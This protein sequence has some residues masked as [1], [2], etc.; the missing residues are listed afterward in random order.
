VVAIPDVA[1]RV[2]Y[3]RH[4]L[5]RMP[6]ELV[7]DVVAIAANLNET[8]IP[9][10]PQ[11]LLSISLALADESANDI[12]RAALGVAAS[13]GQRDVVLLLGR[14]MKGGEAEDEEEDERQIPDFG[15]GRPLTLGERKSLARK[16]DRDLIMRVLR[17]PHADVIEIL[18]GNPAVTEDDVI[19]LAA[20]RPVGSTILR[21]IFRSTRW[22]VRYR[23]Q[24]VLCLNPHTPLDVSLSLVRHL[25]AVDRKLVRESTTLPEELRR[26]GTDEE[27]EV[28]H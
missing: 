18:L 15:A 3:V 25:N 26:A 10:N 12:R 14:R 4:Q 22:I 11:L 7:A 24:R 19:R 5:T 16:R 6:P 8:R 21:K 23:I 28:L 20:R 17:D 27:V 1:M 13:R 2:A 9:P